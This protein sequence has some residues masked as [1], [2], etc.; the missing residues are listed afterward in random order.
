MI[1]IQAMTTV[2]H[3]RNKFKEELSNVFRLVYGLLMRLGSMY[4]PGVLTINSTDLTLNLK[5]LK[6][7]NG[8]RLTQ[9]V[10]EITRKKTPDEFY[11]L[12]GTILNMFSDI[13]RVAFIPHTF[14]ANKDK[15]IENKEDYS[16]SHVNTNNNGK[17]LFLPWPIHT[18]PR[19]LVKYCHIACA[20]IGM[21]Y[22]NNLY[23]TA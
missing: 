23:I 11:S 6:A 2:P 4:L 14:D 5:N 17:N 9:L 15:E 1:Q 21:V 20:V 12:V 19:L 7:N 22:L 16:T 3:K 18:M 10:K 13:V 8:G